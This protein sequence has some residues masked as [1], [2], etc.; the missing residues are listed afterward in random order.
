MSSAEGHEKLL[1][2]LLELSG[3]LVTFMGYV[4]AHPGAVA[5]FFA[6]GLLSTRETTM[7]GVP[8]GDRVLIAVG[9]A[10]ITVAVDDITDQRLARD[11]ELGIAMPH[12]RRDCRCYIVETAY[13]I[14]LFQDSEHHAS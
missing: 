14:L 2:A 4:K 1:H 5:D 12:I 11:A 3:E 13:S 8:A 7:D 9:D 10:R 6:V